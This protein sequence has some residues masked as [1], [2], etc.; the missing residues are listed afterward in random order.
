MRKKAAAAF[1]ALAMILTLFTF[2][3]TASA[4]DT[5]DVQ[6]SG[7]ADP[8]E[9]TQ[10][11]YVD[12]TFIILN[13][14]SVRIDSCKIKKG[15]EPPL[16]P[17]EFSVEPGASNSDVVITYSVQESEIGHSIQFTLLYDNSETGETVSVTTP[18]T[19]ARKTA[20]VK[21]DMTAIPDKTL[22]PKGQSV[23]IGYTLQNHGDVDITELTVTD[24]CLKDIPGNTVV[25]NLTLKVNESVTYTKNITVNEDTQSAAVATYKAAG[26]D[27]ITSAPTQ[28]IKV[29][30]ALLLITVTAD[31]TQ[32]DTGGTVTL[33][34]KL[35]N[36]GNVR[37]TDIKLTDDKGHQI[38]TVLGIEAGKYVSFP[39]T[40]IPDST[41]TYIFTANGKDPTGV[42][43]SSESAPLEIKVGT[44]SAGSGLS[45]EVQPAADK[46]EIPGT[47]EF[48]ITL[49]NTGTSQLYNV[50]VTEDV[51]G[52]VE[53]LATLDVGEEVLHKEFQVD[54]TTIY[55]FKVTAQDINGV[56]YESRADAVSVSVGTPP[57]QAP[58][59]IGNLNGLLILLIVIAAL[60]IFVVAALIF[61]LKKG[62]VKKRPTNNDPPPSGGPGSRRGLEI[63]RHSRYHDRTNF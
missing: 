33:S 49:R 56:G 63:K 14:L 35:E 26:S 29:V 55:T 42:A 18:V 31:K 50:K 40:F 36:T 59:G 53:S 44:Q 30:S 25:S 22:V 5:G 41:N 15:E 3:P 34:F 17:D 51:L 39:Y 48:T 19:I 27:H 7:T 10:P 37:L 23:N 2:M 46:I 54:K 16:N 24:P 11:G 60:V 1:M 4:T 43:F 61:V 6:F 9:L 8:S 47:V 20:T 32:V 45:I 38:K 62:K 12:I 52:E 28:D 57:S 58:G 21:L 13:N